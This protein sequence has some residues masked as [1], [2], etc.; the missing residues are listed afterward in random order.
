MKKLISA[1][2]AMA[3]AFSLTACGAKE[4]PAPAPAPRLCPYCKSAIADDAT[5]CPHC[6]S[7][8]N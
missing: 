1:M 2:L 4:E 5:R 7:Q 3:M 8:L 6:T